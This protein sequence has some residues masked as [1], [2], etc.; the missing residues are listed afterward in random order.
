M[1]HVYS[2]AGFGCWA[3][4]PEKKEHKGNVIFYNKCNKS[5]TGM[6]TN[7]FQ[8]C[9]EHSAKDLKY[10]RG[11]ARQVKKSIEDSDVKRVYMIGHSFGGFV[12]SI[13]AQILNSHPMAHKL[14]I[15]TYGTIMA[16]DPGSCPGVSIRQY[17]YKGD[18][19]LQC[20]QNRQHIKWLKSPINIHNILDA[21]RAHMSY[22]FESDSAYLV[23]R[24]DGL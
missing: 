11:V 23:K 18:I 8:T 6:M 20:V 4:S 24:Y 17:M 7:I 22:P 15:V 14:D 12:C 3:F 5:M 19:S 2:V 1:Y 10:A 16:I 9:W 13:V 21:V